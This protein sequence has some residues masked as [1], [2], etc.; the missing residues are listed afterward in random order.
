MTEKL[1]EYL[2]EYLSYWKSSLE[3][4]A[5]ELTLG[6]RSSGWRV[7]RNQA[8]EEI[9]EC[10]VCGTKKELEAHHVVPYWINKALELVRSN[11]RVLCRK[12]HYLFGHR[13][14]WKSYNPTIDEDIKIWREKI[15]QRP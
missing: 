9:G 2:I 4:R 14:S 6:A 10:E 13:Y 3:K 12:C 5:A 7:V 1:L 11:L 15:Q 8:V